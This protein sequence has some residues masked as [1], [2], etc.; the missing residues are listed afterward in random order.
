MNAK[1][2]VSCLAKGREGGISGREV[3][4]EIELGKGK[5]GFC[6]FAGESHPSGDLVNYTSPTLR[7]CTGNTVIYSRN[8][9]HPAIRISPRGTAPAGN[10]FALYRE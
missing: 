7:M 9:P 4:I 8:S 6:G 1:N 5:S 2:S 10:L 3:E